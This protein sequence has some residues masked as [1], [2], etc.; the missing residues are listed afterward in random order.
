MRESVSPGQRK[1]GADIRRRNIMFDIVQLGLIVAIAAA[2]LG[3]ALA[4]AWR[5]A[6]RDPR[7]SRT[8][9]H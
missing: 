9:Q 5:D 6:N 3:S 8:D 2:I 1:A 4:Y 7:L